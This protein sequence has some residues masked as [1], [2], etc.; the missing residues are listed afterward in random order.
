M[1]VPDKPMYSHTT[2]QHMPYPE[3]PLLPRGSGWGRR[4]TP[5]RHR[6]V[7]ATAC[8]AARPREVSAAAQAGLESDRSALAGP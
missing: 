5:Q 3:A 4:P 1:S 2:Y 8:R 7:S 6:A